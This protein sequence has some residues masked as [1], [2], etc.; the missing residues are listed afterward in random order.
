MGELKSSWSLFTWGRRGRKVE[1]QMKTAKGFIG[2]TMELGFW[3]KKGV[4]AAVFEDEKAL[5]EFAHTGQHAMCFKESK[6]DIKGEMEKARWSISGSALPL[7]LKNAVDKIQEQNS[8][9][10]T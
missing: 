6:G 10:S 4:I 8:S 9:R 3:S 7:T 1:E 2:F 5:T